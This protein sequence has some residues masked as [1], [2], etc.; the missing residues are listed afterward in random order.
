MPPSRPSVKHPPS[1]PPPPSGV[2]WSGRTRRWC[3]SRPPRGSRRPSARSPPLLAQ[4][5]AAGFGDTVLVVHLTEPSGFEEEAR[6]PRGLRAAVALA[7]HVDRRAGLADPE[8]RSRRGTG[9]APRSRPPAD[10]RRAAAMLCD[11]LRRLLLLFSY[12]FI[13]ASA[14]DPAR[15]GK[16]LVEGAGPR[17]SSTGAV[18]RLVLLARG[19][20]APP[21]VPRPLVGAGHPPARPDP[22][23]GVAA[24]PAPRA[25]RVLLARLDAARRLAGGLRERLSGAAIEPQGEPYPQSR[26]V[27]ERVPGAPRSPRARRPRADGAAPRD[28]A[29]PRSRRGDRPRWARALTWRRVGVAL[30]GSGAWGYAHVALMRQLE[31]RGVP[32][33]IVGGS[34]SGALMGAFYAVLGRAG[35][36]RAIAAG[37]TPG[38][39][40]LARR[41]SRPPS[42]TWAPTPSSAAPSSR[43]SRSLF[44]PV[45]A[46]LSARPRRGHHPVHRRLRGAAPARS[47]PGVF[48]ATITRS[49]L[50]VDGAITDNVP[51]Q[52]VERMGADLVV[53]CNP[54]PPP[55]AISSHAEDSPLADFLAELNPVNRLRDLRV[56]FEM[57]MH[58]FGDCEP[59]ETRVVYEPPDAHPSSAPSTSA[60]PAPGRGRRSR[61][62]LFRKD[63]RAQRRSLGPPRRSP[64]TL[65]SALLLR[66]PSP[67]RPLRPE[68]EPRP[69]RPHPRR[70]PPRLRLRPRA[71]GPGD[72]ARR[73]RRHARRDARP[74]DRRRGA[75]GDPGHHRR[76]RPHRGRPQ[77]RQGPPPGGDARLLRHR[78]GDEGGRA[79]GRRRLH[80][81]AAGAGGRPHGRRLRAE[82]QAHPGALR[83]EAV[84]RA[85]RQAGDEE[86]GPRRPRG[87]RPAPPPRRRTWTGC[88]WSS[89]TTTR[90]GRRPTARR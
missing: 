88:S 81:R 51:V 11:R 30:G 24:Q 62:P 7:L 86:R 10:P 57:M 8:H 31:G 17:P 39:A 41:S 70:R 28:L 29:P 36:D 84:E 45:A 68:A 64:P 6:W 1:L 12:V 87:G 61:E 89:S 2:R 21:P 82:Q 43:I 67:P 72:P 76:A 33:D 23:G 47:A 22:R 3:S 25:R 14:R 15:C 78:A 20:S 9:G 83:G 66:L 54:L 79:D 58:D 56:S 77:A 40:G 4:S 13:D 34:S 26:V 75:A 35:L 19:E 80:R 73:A 18:R 55:A 71:Q 32:I 69:P 37:T 85:A 60:A 27:P 90:C 53:A 48:A 38:A 52:L 65:L 49:G 50:Y 42:S 16:P 59:S 44:L 46:N 74:R 5:L 63:H